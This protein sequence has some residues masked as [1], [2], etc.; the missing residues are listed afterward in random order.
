MKFKNHNIN[1]IDTHLFEI[2]KQGEMR[3][4]GRVYASSKMM[5]Q[6]MEEAEPLQ[7]VINVAHLPGIHQNALAM[8]DIHWGYGFPI[9]GVAATDW[10]DGV[11]S[12]GG[13]GYDINCGVRL[14]ST[15]LNNDQIQPKKAKLVQELFHKIPTGVGSSHAIRKLSNK[16]LCNAITRGVSWVIN[17]GFGRT[18]DLA[19]TEENG[20]LPNADAD[21]VSSR[22]MERGRDQMGTLGSGNHFL[23][24]GKVD[25]IYDEV[26]AQVLG[27]FKDQIVILIH[28]GSRGLGYQ[29]CEDYLKVMGQASQKYRIKL[30]DRQLAS[31][32]IQSQEG[33]QYLAA[34]AC[35][36]NFAWCNRQVIMSLAEKVFQQVLHIS[37]HELGANLIYDISH[38]IAKKEQHI[39]NDKKQTVCVHRKGATRAFGPENPVLPDIYKKIGQLVLIPGDMGRYSYLCLGTKK[40]EQE[41]FGS[42]C[43][44]AGRILSRRQAKKKASGRNL[45]K[46]LADKNII[47]QTRGKGTMAEEMPDAYKDVSE[48][49]EVMHQSGITKKVV[50]LRPIGVIKG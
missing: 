33:S 18:S 41:T 47:V 17:Q 13:V 12:P 22:A 16:E 26:S 25:R 38:N 34:M 2:E 32:P 49:V 24:I 29:I 11:I 50:R 30:P 20:C 6:L 43:H 45:F 40:A 19:F 27:L 9:G 7:Q 36:A 1:Q 39:V 10:Q 21:L 8:P 35:A 46:E 42:S 4:N 44:G 37:E 31:A 28:T 15:Q 14:I 23:E 3:V 48:V 5:N